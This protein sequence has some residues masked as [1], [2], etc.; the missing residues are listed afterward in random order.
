MEMNK[1]REAE[2][3]RLRRELDESSR[4]A[5]SLAAALKKRHGDTLAELGEQCDGLQRTRAKLEKEKQNLR[6][7]VDD[8]AAS[9]DNLQKAKVSQRTQNRCLEGGGQATTRICAARLD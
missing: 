8:L 5:E 9:L 4:Q 7:E 2:L 3:Q 6:L 1:K